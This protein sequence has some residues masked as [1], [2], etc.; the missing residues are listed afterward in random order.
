MTEWLFKVR[1]QGC[2]ARDAQARSVGYSWEKL[3][4]GQG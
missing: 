4:H 2:K 1:L 3:D